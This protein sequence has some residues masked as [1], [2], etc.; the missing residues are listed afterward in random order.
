ME[1]GCV[2]SETKPSSQSSI[3][4]KYSCEFCSK[5]FRAPSYLREHERI[6]TRE[7]PYSCEICEKTFRTK[8]NLR[9][10]IL[11]VHVKG[12]PIWDNASFN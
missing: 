7:K 1:R 9:A 4:K 5:K 2:F 10:H 12:N 11:N 8:S 6:H 3:Q